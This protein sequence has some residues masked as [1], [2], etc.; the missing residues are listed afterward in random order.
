MKKFLPIFVLVLAAFPL[1]VAAQ[2][3]VDAI[4][5]AFQLA[6]TIVLAVGF[7]VALILLIV[8]GI[9]YITSG[10]DEEKAGSAKKAIIN[11]VIGIVIV[12][13]AVFIITIAQGLVSDVDIGNPLL[14]PC[15]DLLEP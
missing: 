8:A 11:A 9:K 1:I 3:A 12:I 6:K 10:G 7:G 13:A 14:N 4:C 2:D 5:A 15:P